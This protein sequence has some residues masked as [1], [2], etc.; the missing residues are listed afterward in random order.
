MKKAVVV[1]AG[2]GGL[3]TALLLS[4]QGFEVTIIEKNNRIGGKMGEVNGFGYRFDTG[5]SLLT[6]PFLLKELFERCGRKL[7]DYLTLVELEH[8]CHY[9]FSDGTT[10]ENWADEKKTID[11]IRRIAPED[12]HN[13][14]EFL[15]YSTRLFALTKDVFLR[16]PLFEWSDLKSLPILNLLQIDAFSTVSQKIDRSLNSPYIRQFFKRFTTYNGSSPFKAPAT[17]NVIPHVELRMGAFYVR[18]GMYSIAKAIKKAC[19]ES[20]CRWRFEEEVIKMTGTK[21]HIKSVILTSGEQ[22]EADLV[23]CNADATYAIQNLLSQYSTKRER[24]RARNTEPSSSGYVILLG[25]DKTWDQLRH[26]NIFFSADYKK[27][28]DDIFSDK[29]CPEDPTIYVTNTSITDQEDAPSGHSNLFILVNTPC[30]PLTCSSEYGD[31]LIRL[32]ELRGLD[33]LSEHIRFRQDILPHEFESRY[34]SNRGSIYGT[35]SNGLFSAFLRPRN[36]HQR[37][38]NLYF[39]GGSTHP[40][41]GIPLVLLSS[42][43]TIELLKRRKQTIRRVR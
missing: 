15:N 30:Q 29:R 4:S 13:Y 8:L 17:L 26:H 36:A 11:E 20:S 31:Q 33:G 25:V 10:F 32:L 3:S 2:M 18:G 12:E 22:I 7:E 23:V 19:D 38:Q 35:S 28:F 16:N 39:T 42:F 41:G 21:D 40:G 14:T 24:Q 1:G 37:I 27:E 34:F 5:P 6:M 43:H 9:E